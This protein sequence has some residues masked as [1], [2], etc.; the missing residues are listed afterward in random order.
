[1]GAFLRRPRMLDIPRGLMLNIIGS[2]GPSRQR[3][4]ENANKGTVASLSY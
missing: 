2:E 4:M 3:I 1:M